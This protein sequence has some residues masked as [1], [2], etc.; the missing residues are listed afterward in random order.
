MLAAGSVVA[1]SPAALSAQCHGCEGFICLAGCPVNDRNNCGPTCI[2]GTS[3]DGG[4]WCANDTGGCGTGLLDGAGSI[5]VPTLRLA[6][7]A[8]R[9]DLF[10]FA[11]VLSGSS[12]R[13]VASEISAEQVL[14]RPC[15]KAVV[16]R[17]YTPE[18]AQEK[19]RAT[20]L[21]VL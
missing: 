5:V 6:D 9:V 13:R 21:I 12:P 1:L 20:T 2:S 15:D 8:P 17:F 18:V 10:Q 4:Q 14:V 11:T 7:V 3:P 19:R 16:H